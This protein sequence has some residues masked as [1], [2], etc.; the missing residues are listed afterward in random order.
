MD[1]TFNM[2]N[3]LIVQTEGLNWVLSL[4]E[5]L[6]QPR[7]SRRCQWFPGIYNLLVNFYISSFFLGQ[8]CVHQIYYV[9][10]SMDISSH[11]NVRECSQ[12]QGDTEYYCR[13]CDLNLCLPCKTTH[14]IK[15]DTKDH[16][17]TTYREKLN[18]V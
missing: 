10:A 8:S 7:L 1:I 5:N 18:S 9:M 3:L 11:V 17:V 15:L 6:C 4:G 16:H 12:C 2:I 14:T 13:T